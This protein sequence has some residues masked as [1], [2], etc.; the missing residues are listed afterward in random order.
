MAYLVH[1]DGY[2]PFKDYPEHEIRALYLGQGLDLG[3]AT[4][5]AKIFTA[6]FKKMLQREKRLWKKIRRHEVAAGAVLP[7]TAR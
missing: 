4:K 5:Q 1:V 6:E 2:E 7:G 3:T